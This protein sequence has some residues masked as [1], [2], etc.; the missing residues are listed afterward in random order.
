VLP[1]LDGVLHAADIHIVT[2]GIQAPVLPVAMT[3]IW[4]DVKS[5]ETRVGVSL[6]T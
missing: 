6:M 4:G 5:S 1:I 2:T 3:V